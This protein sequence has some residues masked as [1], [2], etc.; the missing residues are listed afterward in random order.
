MLDL[1][2][3]NHANQH[4]GQHGPP[5]KNG[6]G[7]RIQ[8]CSTFVR[9]FSPLGRV[10]IEH[11]KRAVGDAVLRVVDPRFTGFHDFG[12]DHLSNDPVFQTIDRVCNVV[13]KVPEEYSAERL[14]E[15]KNPIANI[16]PNVDA[17]SGSLLYHCG[18]TEVPYYTVLFAV[19]RIMGMLA[20]LILNRAMGTAITRP[21]SGSTEWIEKKV[22]S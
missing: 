5:V 7:E 18:L 11:G 14:K 19:S 6:S 16:W 9:E 8:T 1:R 20:Q 10:R 12:K 15:G 2:V 3:E 17:I 4:A 21:K 13:P 22:G